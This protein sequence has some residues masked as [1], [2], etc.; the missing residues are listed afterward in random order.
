MADSGK[1]K[2]FRGLV[3][4][5]GHRSAAVVDRTAQDQKG[6][7]AIFYFSQTLNSQFP[8][9]APHNFREMFH[10]KQPTGEGAGLSA[11]GRTGTS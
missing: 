9:V 10:V 3:R 8:A 5:K 11:H 6:S 7:G 2:A 1:G 4:S